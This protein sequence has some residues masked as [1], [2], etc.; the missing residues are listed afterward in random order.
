MQVDYAELQ[1]ETREIITELLNDGSD[2]D[3]LYIIEHHI[4]HD[5]FEQLEKV[6][7][8][9]FKL[10]FEVADAEEFD[11]EGQVFYAFDALTESPLKPEIIDEQQKQIIPVLQKFNATYDGWG[12]YFEDPNGEEETDAVLFED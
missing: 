11:E 12:T 7:V 1:L 8:E 3:A 6:A 9:M 5:N 10:G 2:P 4:A